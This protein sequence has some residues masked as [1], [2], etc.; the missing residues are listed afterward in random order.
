VCL[1]ALARLRL[2]A[3]AVVSG[4]GWSCMVIPAQVFATVL[5]SSSSINEVFSGAVAKTEQKKHLLFSS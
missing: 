3:A 4:A 1:Q 5:N 2:Y